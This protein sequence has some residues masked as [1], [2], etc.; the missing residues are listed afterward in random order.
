M[1]DLGREDVWIVDPGLG[2][3]DRDK[4]R[5]MS[6]WRDGDVRSK[7][8]GG[9][10]GKVGTI[11]LLRHGTVS[12]E[13]IVQQL[14]RTKWVHDGGTLVDRVRIVTDPKT[15]GEE[16][17]HVAPGQTIRHY[18][19][20]LPSY[21]VARRRCRCDE[22][23]QQQQ[24][25]ENLRTDDLVWTNEEKGLLNSAVVIDFGGRLQSY[26]TSALAY[27]DLSDA[28]YSKEAA[29]NVFDALRWSETIERAEWVYFPEIGGGD[30][31]AGDTNSDDVVDALILAVKDRLTRAASGV[32][33]DTLI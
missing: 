19:P 28:G 27:R 18:L 33:I 23:N 10:D 3:K 30:S 32:V 14:R 9:D 4:G 2:D 8:K 6:G 24:Q 17:K 11:A 21:M 15:T 31:D 22:G 16:V 5:V 26:K 13:D 7:R 20:N 12:A 29:A 25:R 1:D